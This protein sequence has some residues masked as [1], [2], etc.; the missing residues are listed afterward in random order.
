MIFAKSI[1][2]RGEAM[3]LFAILSAGALVLAGCG[4]A[5][6]EASNSAAAAG[7]FDN[8]AMMSAGNDAA[9]AENDV[10]MTSA[11][12]APA[13][14]P[15]AAPPTMSARPAPMPVMA[16]PPPPPPPPP[17]DGNAALPDAN[18]MAAA[19]AVEGN[20]VA[21]NMADGNS[22]AAPADTRIYCDV[23]HDRISAADCAYNREVWGRLD[24]GRAALD[25]PPAMTRGH[26][27]R[28]SFAL[29]RAA[30][31]HPHDIQNPAELLDTPP[32]MTTG[33]RVGRRMA[34]RLDG[35]G[36]TIEPAGLVERDLVAG[37]AARWDWTVTPLE[38]G[39]RR[40]T[41]S[42]YAIV[43]AANGQRGENLIRTLSRDVEVRVSRDV[44]VE[45]WLDWSKRMIERFNAWLLAVAALIGG[46]VYGVV[47][48]IRKVRGRRGD[49][50]A[51]SEGE[52]EGD[53][54]AAHDGPDAG[55]S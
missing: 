30:E 23:T 51:E 6:Q 25:A 45:D 46:G 20:E 41:I 2:T 1:S 17:A 24:P 35:V 48:A 8:A 15:E 47:V 50:A 12:P 40:L 34:V 32:E 29:T 49:S 3:R 14:A 9:M 38:G 28:V 44:Q 42:A 11:E 53:S 4:S 18:E 37:G 22:T 36:F 21:G 55:R 52:G 13:S 54:G 19:N 26:A 43:Q 33:T 10:M 27:E 16:M 39:H 7:D 5:R 31:G